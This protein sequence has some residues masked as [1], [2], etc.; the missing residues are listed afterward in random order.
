MYPPGCPR[1]FSE[2]QAGLKFRDPLPLPPVCWINGVHHHHMGIVS[3][4]KSDSN[5][6]LLSHPQCH[7]RESFKESSISF[8]CLSLLPANIYYMVPAVIEEGIRSQKLEVKI[9]VKS[10]EFQEANLDLL[11]E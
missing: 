8:V 10:C 6:D 1:T 11:Q 7:L 5:W 2:D 9:V 3:P 4:L